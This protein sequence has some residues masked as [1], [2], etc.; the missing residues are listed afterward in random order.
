MLLSSICTKSSGEDDTKYLLIQNSFCVCPTLMASLDFI[1][2]F[3]YSFDKQLLI[4]FCV[5]D[6][7]LDAGDPDITKTEFC[8][9]GGP[10][11]A[12]DTAK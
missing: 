1:H 8:Y 9:R 6:P 12:E 3:I 2:S 11:L 7:V 4:T 5:W 10:S